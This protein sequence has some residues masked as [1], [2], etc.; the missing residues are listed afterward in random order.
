MTIVVPKPQ[1]AMLARKRHSAGSLTC[2]SDTNVSTGFQ[3][4][5]KYHIIYKLSLANARAVVIVAMENVENF[6]KFELIKL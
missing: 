5:L 6:C 3:V 2:P 4:E 1:Q